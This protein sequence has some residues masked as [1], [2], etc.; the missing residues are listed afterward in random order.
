[1][2]TRRRV[3]A[4][5]GLDGKQ[6]DDTITAFR[7]TVNDSFTEINSKLELAGKAW[8]LVSGAVGGA[9]SAIT[10]WTKAAMEAEAAERKAIAGL[11]LR[12]GATQKNIDKLKEFN[13]ALQQKGVADADDLLALQGQLAALGVAPSKLEA[14]TKATLGLSEATGRGLAGSARKVAQAFTK[15]NG[16]EKGLVELFELAEARAGSLDAKIKTLTSN[17]GDFEETLG[18]AFTSSGVLKGSIDSVNTALTSVTNYFSDPKGRAAINGFFGAIV[19]WGADVLDVFSQII[20]GMDTLIGRLTLAVKANGASLALRAAILMGGG[21]DQ[22]PINTA[23]GILQKLAGDFRKTARTRGVEQPIGPPPG[24]TPP[25]PRPPGSGSKTDPALSG[26]KNKEALF[27]ANMF[28]SKEGNEAIL[29]TEQDAMEALERRRE[30]FRQARIRG[31]QRVEDAAV[32]LKQESIAKQLRL[33]E[34]SN[35]EMTKL[36]DGFAS[37]ALDS[38]ATSIST[39][40]QALAE[41]NADAGDVAK[42]LTGGIIQ[43]FGGLLIQL[44]TAAVLAG[45]IGTAIPVFL[46]ITGGPAGVAAGLAA[47]AA[48]SVMVGLGGALA[49]SGGGQAARVSGAGSR[50]RSGFGVPDQQ[51]GFNLGFGTGGGNVTNVTNVSVHGLIVGSERGLAREIDRIQRSGNTMTVG[52]H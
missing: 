7:K 11:Q 52:A 47:I 46:G 31:D 30:E 51:R 43:A 35:E 34:Q 4:E 9:V 12:G 16:S 32:E 41:G 38:L 39:V 17:Y 28:G 10:G 44:G 1:M 8:S 3:T 49:H 23:S 36:K 48:G 18:A 40:T 2:A 22:A 33:E 13:N 37:V 25:A 6:A 50:G 45:G 42:A 26:P 24:E 19:E 21:Q 29:K 15:G 14:A 5:L 20:R 27:M